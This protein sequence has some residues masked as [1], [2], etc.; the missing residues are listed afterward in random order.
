MSIFVS[1][2]VGDG[3][4][5]AA[6][7]NVTLTYADRAGQP[8]ATVQ[9]VGAKILRWPRQRALLGYVGRAEA[10]GRSMHEYLY[11]FMGDHIGFADPAAVANDLRNRLQAQIGGPG[12]PASIVQFATF[13]RRE[14]HIVPE[15]WHIT[16]VHGLDESG[17]Y[18]PPAADFIAEEQMFKP[19]PEGT[20][21]PDTIRERLRLAADNFA[22]MWFHQGLDLAIFNTCSEAV[23]QAFALLHRARRLTPP[24]SLQDWERHCR[25]WVLMYGAYFEAFGAPGQRYVGGGADVLSIPWPDNL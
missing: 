9:D 20:A 24:G 8:V 17:D 18:L 7:R 12:Q 14:G 19:R 15:Y 23:R 1:E 6:D 3:I 16:N 5:F 10:E 25:M 4:V 2:I 11:D 22:P 13:A 21:S